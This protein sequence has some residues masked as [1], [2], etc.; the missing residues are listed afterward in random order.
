[1]RRGTGF[2]SSHRTDLK[3]GRRPVRS[4]SSP[5]FCACLSTCFFK[6]SK[7][8][9]R[10]NLLPY[11]RLLIG[12]STSSG[13]KMHQIPQL[14]LKLSPF[15]HTQI[16]MATNFLHI[17]TLLVIVMIS[18]ILHSV[19]QHFHS[20]F[21]T[22]FSTECDIVLPLSISIIFSFSLRSLALFVV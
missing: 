20:L 7:L 15:T 11:L 2:G 17:C 4:F 14:P 22:E 13:V 3:E 18:R 21:Q 5:T 1:M 16:Y 10:W 8:K 12:V 19:W 6:K 9:A